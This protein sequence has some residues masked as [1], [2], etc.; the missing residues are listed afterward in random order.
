MT[1]ATSDALEQVIIFG[2][3][4]NRMSASGLKEEILRTE[5]EIREHL[6]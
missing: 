3:G 4:A 1:V 5:K 6:L 2:A